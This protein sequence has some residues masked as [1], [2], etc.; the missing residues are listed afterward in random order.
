[1][2]RGRVHIRAGRTLVVQVVP[3]HSMVKVEITTEPAI[4]TVVSV[5]QVNVSSSVPVFYGEYAGHLPQR[6]LPWPVTAKLF[7]VVSDGLPNPCRLT[8]PITVWPS[9][10]LRVTWWV[11]VFLGLVGLRWQYT[12]AHNNS[13]WDV[14]PQ[15]GDDLPYIGGLFLLGF[16]V[17]ALLHLFGWVATARAPDEDL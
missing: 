8:I 13:V 5:S 4:H 9:V 16:P 14:L 10:R 2:G 15:L 1:M 11:L 17:L 3:P 6:V 12:L 7:V